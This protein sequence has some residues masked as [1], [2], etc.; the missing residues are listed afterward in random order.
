M[1]ESRGR[2][3]SAGRKKGGRVKGGEGGRGGKGLTEVDCPVCFCYVL[4]DPVACT[5][6]SVMCVFVSWQHT[7]H[8]NSE[9][10]ARVSCVLFCDI[11]TK[12]KQWIKTNNKIIFATKHQPPHDSHPLPFYTFDTWFKSS[13]FFV[14]L[15]FFLNL[16]TKSSPPQSSP[17]S[18]TPTSVSLSVCLSPSFLPLSFPLTENWLSPARAGHSSFWRPSVWRGWPHCC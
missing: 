2:W 18:T 15:L 10:H 7:F 11:N 17:F 14:F 12:Q 5:C 1:T 6:V 16:Y 3:E 8:G 9:T 13:F 4:R